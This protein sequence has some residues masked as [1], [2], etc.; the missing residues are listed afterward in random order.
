MKS[1][2]PPARLP[3]VRYPEMPGDPVKAW[4][5]DERLRLLRNVKNPHDFVSL[6]GLQM[7]YF[8]EKVSR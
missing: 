8:K 5:F 7:E 6:D 3:T 2:R 1:G 4:F